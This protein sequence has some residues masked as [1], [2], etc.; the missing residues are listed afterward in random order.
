MTAK[1]RDQ[2]TVVDMTD[3]QA[4]TIYYLLQASTLSAPAAPTTESPTNWTTTEPTFDNSTTE[5]LYTCVRTLF[6]NGSFTWGDVSVSSSYEAAKNAYNAAQTAQNTADLNYQ[7]MLSKF[8]DSL[9]TNGTGFLGD[10]T[11]F[12]S[13]E[14]DQTQIFDGVSGVF[15]RNL[16]ASHTLII[17]EFLPFDPTKDYILSF[18]RKNTLA[19]SYEYSMPVLYDSD[20]YPISFPYCHWTPGTTTTLSQDL[21]NGDT[22]IHFTDLTNWN[23]T[24]TYPQQRSVIIWDYK[25][26]AGYQYPPETYSRHYYA[27]A[28]LYSDNSAVDKTNNTITLSS[29]WSHGSKIA[30]TSISQGTT[31]ASYMYGPLR[32]TLIPTEWTK[33]SCVIGP[34]Q[35]MDKNFLYGAAFLKIGF[36][37]A[38]SGAHSSSEYGYLGN[39][40]MYEYTA[41][42]IDLDTTNTNVTKAQETADGKN[43]VYRQSSQPSGGTYKS[44]DVWFDTDNGN[45]I[46]TYSGSAWLKTE[47]GSNAIAANAIIADLIA[48]NAITTDKLAANSI[49]TSK[50]ATDAIKSLNYV[51]DSAGMFLN[52]TDGTIDSKNFKVDASGNITI[53]NGGITIKNNNGTDVFLTDSNGNL[54]ITGALRMSGSQTVRIDNA[55]GVLVGQLLFEA[56]SGVTWSPGALKVRGY[57]YTT[58]EAGANTEVTK[59]HGRIMARGFG[60]AMF[61]SENYGDHDYSFFGFGQ[62]GDL[63]GV[64]T[65]S[66]SSTTSEQMVFRSKQFPQIIFG[67]M[68]CSVANDSSVAMFD[69]STLNTFLGTF[70]VNNLNTV[71]VVG[72]G[73]GGACNAH[74]QG[75]TYLNGTWYTTIDRIF[76]GNVRVNYAVISYA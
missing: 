34:H 42:Q 52:L 49:L 20:K 29:P 6:A 16:D 32:N 69:N 61:G 48:S 15:K 26:N 24:T 73:D 59:A 3:V 9:V 62:N 22:I 11:N 65:V 56:L 8:Q 39:V 36:F 1:A 27:Y 40:K 31:G 50:L 70:G 64:K 30:G 45:A 76:T 25:N 66:T 17:D 12:S 23:V 10:N 75:C 28:G 13:W 19:G 21:N 5:T 35:T 18:Y 57:D 46:Y 47:M 72:N 60:L 71:V 67:S 58:L 53:K 54:E 68:V 37:W 2:V 44:G 14:F 33:Y 41:S 38:Y 43:A 7:K 63:L 4:V 74:C 55:S 51:L